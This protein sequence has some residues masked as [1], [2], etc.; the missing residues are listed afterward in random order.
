M[1]VPYSALGLA[2]TAP[3]DVLNQ[4]L[5]TFGDMRFEPPDRVPTVTKAAALTMVTNDLKSVSARTDATPVYTKLATW[6]DCTT[7]PLSTSGTCA[8][9]AKRSATGGVIARVL[10]WLLVRPNALVGGES[11]GPPS[12]G[13]SAADEKATAAAQANARGDTFTM[14]N[15]LTGER[16]GTYQTWGH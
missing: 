13:Q 7:G 11:T 12:P 5:V 9:N 15:A 4:P 3:G 2:V 8:D 14:V 10:V 16:Y 1:T 6:I